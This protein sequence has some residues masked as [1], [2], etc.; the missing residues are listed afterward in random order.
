MSLLNRRLESFPAGV[1]CS[2]CT[3]ACRVRC[4]SRH[5]FA[6]GGL[7]AGAGV[8]RLFPG[9][10]HQVTR[11]LLVSPTTGPRMEGRNDVFLGFG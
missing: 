8:G 9:S 2:L 1:D 10:T 11:L 5:G 7:N 4:S 3:A 6:S